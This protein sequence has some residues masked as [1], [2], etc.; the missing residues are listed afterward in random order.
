MPLLTAHLLAIIWF[1]N[2]LNNS[3]SMH[4]VLLRNKEL[5]Q[6]SVCGS[7]LLVNEAG[8]TELWVG[9][10]RGDT[11]PGPPNFQGAPGGFYFHDFWLHLHTVSFS[12]AFHCIVWTQIVECIA[13]CVCVARLFPHTNVIWYPDKQYKWGMCVP[14]MPHCQEEKY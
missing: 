8:V 4:Q 7:S 2:S 6:T 5:L 14:I 13:K 9:P 10:P 11:S 3:I 1:N 12:F